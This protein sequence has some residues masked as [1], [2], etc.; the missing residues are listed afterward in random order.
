MAGSQAVDSLVNGSVIRNGEK[1]VFS[2]T[3]EGD[4]RRRERGNRGGEISRGE[5]GEQRNREG[6]RKLDQKRASEDHNRRKK[7]EKGARGRR[8]IGQLYT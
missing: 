7:E 6:K 8:K 5:E 1:I 3:K 4:E 2:R